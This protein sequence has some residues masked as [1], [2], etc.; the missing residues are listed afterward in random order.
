MY[1][2]ERAK[3]IWREL[4]LPNTFMP[5]SNFGAKSAYGSVYLT[6]G[7]KLLKLTNWTRNSAREFKV[8]KIASE[9]NVGP[10]VWHTLKH[11]KNGKTTA[12]MAMN[13]VP[14]AKS[15]L[16]AI[17]NG[18]IEN[19]HNVQALI[20]KMHQAG[21]HHGNL[22]LGNILVYKN[23]TGALKFTIIDYGASKYHPGIYNSRTAV[24]YAIES[25]GWR[26]GSR[27]CASNA[28]GNPCYRRPGRN[29][30]IRS[31]RN[32]EQTLINLFPEL[33]P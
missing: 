1:N 13:K 24:K 11:V 19:L 31:N 4:G 10:R 20:F 18:N 14:N 5:V 29:Q 32:M 16:S 17:R 33:R 3:N 22:H 30:M 27:Q 6:K 12:V 7:N 28:F 15:L 9:A 23:S 25:R 8:A 2:L 26:G 21:I